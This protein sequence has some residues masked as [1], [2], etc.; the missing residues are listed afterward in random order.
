MHLEQCYKTTTKGLYNYLTKTKDW[1]LKLTLHHEC[2]KKS[3]SVVKESMKFKREFDIEFDYPQL[4]AIEVARKVKK[5][6]S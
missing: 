5:T 3:H 1:M 4:E 2:S 6:L